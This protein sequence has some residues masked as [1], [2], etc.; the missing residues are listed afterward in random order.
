MPTALFGAWRHVPAGSSGTWKMPRHGPRIIPKVP[1]RSSRGASSSQGPEKALYMRD[2]ASTSS[3]SGNEGVPKHVQTRTRS[4]HHYP[5]IQMSNNFWSF[6][7]CLS[8]KWIRGLHSVRVVA[9]ELGERGKFCTRSY[10]PPSI[11]HKIHSLN[12]QC[13]GAGC[14]S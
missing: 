6:S 5:M 12:L 13:R 1:Q 8:V 2:A 3:Q 14:F 7:S 10:Q 9:P 4:Y 11:R